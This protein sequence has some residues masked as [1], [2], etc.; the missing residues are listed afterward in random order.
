VGQLPGEEKNRSLVV[1][2]RVGAWVMLGSLLCVDL[3]LVAQAPS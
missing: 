1:G 3:D 2:S